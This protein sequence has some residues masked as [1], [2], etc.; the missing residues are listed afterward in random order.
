MTVSIPRNFIDQI[1]RQAENDYPH[2]TCGILIGPQNEKEKVTTIYPCRNVQ[3]EYHAL[4]PVNFPRTAETAYFIDPKDLLRIQKESREKQCE[5]RVIYH[6]HVNVGAY[7]SEEDQRI[8]LA[9]GRPAYP[10]VSYIV[11]SVR[12]RKAGEVSLFYW[13]EK[14]ES[15]VKTEFK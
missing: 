12:E 8:A 2:E 5:M 1:L 13:D 6:S 15:F 11:V 4:D 9:D 14:S 10:G 7:F 3:D